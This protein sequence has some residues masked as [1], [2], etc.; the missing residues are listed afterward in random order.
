MF[1]LFNNVTFYKKNHIDH[2]RLIYRTKYR[3]AFFLGAG[4][5]ALIT[6]FKP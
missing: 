4:R 2:I 6:N 5:G 1:I 3:N